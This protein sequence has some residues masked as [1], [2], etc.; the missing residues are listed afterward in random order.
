MT[1]VTDVWD[2][3]L[4]HGLIGIGGFMV[5]NFRVSFKSTPRIGPEIGVVFILC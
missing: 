4:G 3:V 1:V 5:N 2:L